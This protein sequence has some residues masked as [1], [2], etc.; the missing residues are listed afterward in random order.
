MNYTDAI[1]ETD[2]SCKRK[3]NDAELRMDNLS[4]IQKFIH[5]FALYR[6]RQLFYKCQKEYMHTDNEIF[7]M[8]QKENNRRL[9]DYLNRHD[10]IVIGS[11]TIIESCFINGAWGVM[12]PSTQIKTPKVFFAASAD[13]AKNLLKRPELYKELRLRVDDF[14]QIGLRDYVTINFFKEKLNIPEN[15]LIKQPDPTFYLPLS[16]FSIAEHKIKK[17][18]ICSKKVVFYHF[19]RFFKYRKTLADLLHKKGYY[20]ITSEYD[21]NCDYSLRSLTPFEWAAL[22]KYC[23]YVLTERFHDTVFAMRYQVPV[24]T[25]DWR[26]RVMNDNM[27][28][29][30]LS[31]L[32]DFNCSENHFVIKSEDDLKLVVE[33]LSKIGGDSYN[34]KINEKVNEMINTS[35]DSVIKLKEIVKTKTQEC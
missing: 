23:D 21:P 4:I 12:W 19:D 24:V 35:E 25:I 27:E 10:L 2:V 11:D 26:L 17:I 32:K 8:Y 5:F 31:V 22:F 6:R 14:S 28:S 30:R 34:K 16:L 29:K 20:L 9:I 18:P 15:R 1:K 33:K 13:S 7:S 3:L